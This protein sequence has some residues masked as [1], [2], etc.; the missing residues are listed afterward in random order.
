MASLGRK[1]ILNGGGRPANEVNMELTGRKGG[2]GSV[3]VGLWALCRAGVGVCCEDLGFY[4][5]RNRGPWKVLSR[6]V[7]LFQLKDSEVLH[8]CVYGNVTILIILMKLAFKQ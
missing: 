1:A 2:S 5:E 4:S 7:S 8:F 3:D 6:V